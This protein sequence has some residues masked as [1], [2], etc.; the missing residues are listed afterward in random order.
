MPR[1]PFLTSN[2]PVIDAIFT[3]KSNWDDFR[4]DNVWKGNKVSDWL[5]YR[6]GYTPT[7]W[8]EAG[9]LFDMSPERMKRASEKVTTNL[10]NNIYTSIGGQIISRIIADADEASKDEVNETI[11]NQIMDGAHPIIRRYIKFSNPDQKGG[12]LERYNIEENDKRKL[13][14]DRVR[15]A[16]KAQT[17]QKFYEQL[18]DDKDL[19][20]E[21]RRRMLNLFRSAS[22][23][24][25]ID[26]FYTELQFA[27]SPEVKAR[28]YFDRWVD[29]SE[30]ERKVMARTIAIIDN[31]RSER[32]Y[33][34][35]ATL[36]KPYVKKK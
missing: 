12:E 17:Y 2:P 32:F 21:D 7:I 18:I 4:D 9:A 28:A 15:K 29:A 27:A 14:N 8:R 19:L 35:L 6:D 34:A 33:R 24:K 36:Q 3:Y 22:R 11:I 1:I 10:E 26:F 5:E 20:R 30:E 31:I 13:Q 16:V 25:G 23:K